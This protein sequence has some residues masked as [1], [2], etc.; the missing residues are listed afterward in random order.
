MFFIIPGSEISLEEAADVLDLVGRPNEIYLHTK[1][2]FEILKEEQ[3][4]HPI[5]TMSQSIDRLLD[6]GVPLSKVTEISGI[7]GVGKTQIW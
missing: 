4:N 7:A 2:A 5:L 1:T 3:L 6:G